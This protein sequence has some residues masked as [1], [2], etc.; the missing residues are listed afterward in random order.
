MPILGRM[1]YQPAEFGLVVLLVA[2]MYTLIAYF[3][4]RT[5]QAGPS[6]NLY[7]STVLILFVNVFTHVGQT[8][9]LGMYTPGVVTAGLVVLPYTVSAFQTLRAHQLLT[10]ETWR[11]AP[12][13]SAAMLAVIFGLMMVV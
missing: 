4:T 10:S 5:I 12:L 13:M 2:V 11:V 7:V 3:A 8:V 6:M 1:A 9:V